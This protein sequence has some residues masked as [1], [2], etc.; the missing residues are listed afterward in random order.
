MIYNSAPVGSSVVDHQ[1][2]SYMAA[3]VAVVQA[4]FTARRFPNGMQVID[5]F[6]KLLCVLW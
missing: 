4:Q 5:T 2:A 1:L 3:A 6:V